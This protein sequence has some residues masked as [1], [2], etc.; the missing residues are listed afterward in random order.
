[1][2]SSTA[3]S[4]G[5]ALGEVLFSDLITAVDTIMAS[6]MDYDQAVKKALIE[7]RE[8]ATGKALS[9]LGKFGLNVND[10][11][12]DFNSTRSSDGGRVLM[13]IDNSESGGVCIPVVQK[14]NVFAQF[15]NIVDW[16]SPTEPIKPLTIITDATVIPNKLKLYNN[17]PNPFNPT[18]TIS[19][20]LPEET[21][22]ELTIYNIQGQKIRTLQ[23][24]IMRAGKHHIFFDGMDNHNRVLGT[25]VYFYQLITGHFFDNKKM[26]VIK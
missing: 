22:V 8:L 21:F 9:S 3:K 25:G 6:G 26:M 10:G 24:G 16:E 5:Q 23:S 13:R 17:Y 18:T 2:D 7:F 20:D 19:F 15:T 4:V 12:Y 14:R 11:S 1:M